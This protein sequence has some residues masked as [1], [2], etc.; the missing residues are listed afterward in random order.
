M[1]KVCDLV[2]IYDKRNSPALDGVNFNLADAGLV[3]VVGKYR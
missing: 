2:K 3:F 1:I